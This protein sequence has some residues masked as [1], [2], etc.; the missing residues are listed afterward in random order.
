MAYRMPESSS[1]WVS[2]PLVLPIFLLLILFSS[3][4]FAQSFEY[5]G[6]GVDSFI[7]AMG[8]N[9]LSAAI[10]RATFGEEF[11]SGLGAFGPPEESHPMGKMFMI[12]CSGLLA[13]GLFWAAWNG[14][15]ATV[16]TA[17]GGKFM[18]QRMSGSWV[19][20]RFTIGI[21][22]LLPV[23]AG[24]CGAQVLYMWLAKIASGIGNLM[25]LA[26]LPTMSGPAYAVDAAVQ[27]ANP[28]AAVTQLF[29]S[30][31]CMQ[32][33]NRQMT[34]DF[35]GASF[36]QGTDL[37]GETIVSGLVTRGDKRLEVFFHR[38]SSIANKSSAYGGDVACG[39]IAYDLGSQATGPLAAG[40]E[41]NDGFMG[42]PLGQSTPEEI[43]FD[44]NKDAIEKMNKDVE[45]AVSQLMSAV[46]SGG[47][48]PFNMKQKIEEISDAYVTTTTEKYRS[49]LSSLDDKSLDYAKEIIKNQGWI[50][51]GSFY[52]IIGRN[53]NVAQGVFSTNLQTYPINPNLIAIDSERAEA[54]ALAEAANSKQVSAD[55]ALQNLL[56]E[57]MFGGPSLASMFVGGSN[58]LMTGSTAQDGTESDLLFKTVNPI[59]QMKSIGDGLLTTGGFIIGA[60]IGAE[61]AHIGITKLF[62]GGRLATLISKSTPDPK[63]KDAK[64]HESFT[65]GA[66][67][68]IAGTALTLAVVLFI[69][70]FFLAVYIPMLPFIV[71]YG[72]L[73]AWFASLCE[74]IV[75]APVGSF[76]HLDVDG[77]GLGQRTQHSYLFAFNVILRPGCMIFGFSMATLG[78]MVM[79]GILLILFGPAVGSVQS[80]GTM[81]GL[82]MMAGFLIVLI[83][84]MLTMVHSMFNLVH[85]IPDQIVGWA[86]GQVN[87][88]LGKDTDDR[89]K[90][91]FMGGFG[92]TERAMEM[93]SGK[94]P[95]RPPDTPNGGAPAK[96]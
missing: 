35:V 30:H 71:W 94:G 59:F 90:S 67:S 29:E 31:I 47:I 53:M 52:Q 61:I 26:A 24:Y 75:A 73:L 19:P 10:F 25:V 85:I 68:K 63:D 89:A 56:G 13:T 28:R 79:G 70:G 4:A 8:D 76:A 69:F 65:A 55:E 84:L 48:A 3:S 42:L 83:S 60:V 2:L 92:K 40:V 82:F 23:F 14:V 66:F 74:S 6:S 38:K 86:G 93:G 7:G 62:P 22:T 27:G 9:D 77:E 78:V 43:A 34:S 80:N 88:Q 5:T 16:A 58:M 87:T 36:P 44:V 37:D 81:T 50:G 54:Q 18:G 21:S 49:R 72:A 11:Y 95:Q 15:S 45:K 91:V 12:F 1:P 96:K 57:N 32:G 33:V 39:G 41:I 51:F 17:E 20:I 46:S 64:K